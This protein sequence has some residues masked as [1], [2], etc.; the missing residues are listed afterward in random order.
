LQVTRIWRRGRATGTLV[1]I[2]GYWLTWETLRMM[3]PLPE[4][5][6]SFAWEGMLNG[7]IRFRPI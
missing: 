5:V 4:M 6:K 2:E 3:R 1:G 7:A